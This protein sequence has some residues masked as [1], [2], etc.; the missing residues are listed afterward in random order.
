MTTVLRPVERGEPPKPT[1]ALPR[2]RPPRAR[3]AVFALRVP[4]PRRA[5]WT[6]I[7]LSVLLPLGAW[8]L[9]SISGAVSPNN[10]LPTPAA[11]VSA[12]VE[13]ARTGE[14]FTD[15]WSSIQRVLV[16]F[17]LAVALSVPLGI[18]MGSFRAGWALFEP[19]TF[20]W[21]ALAVLA[22]WC[23]TLLIQRS[24]YRDTLA[25]HAKL[26]EL[27]K[28]IDTAE[29]RL[30]RIDEKEPEE[31]EKILEKQREELEDIENA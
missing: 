11:A 4:I 26:D 9:L 28:A 2:R 7:A 18:V 14:L 8:W 24:Q 6:L 13:M 30:A 25:L 31:I 21:S 20:G 29:T 5:R 12:G 27:L 17:G 1:S 22:A 10:Y 16:G 23:M 3:P 15:A 19:K